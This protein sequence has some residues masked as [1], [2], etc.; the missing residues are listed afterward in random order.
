MPAHRIISN[1]LAL[2]NNHHD[3]LPLSALGSGGKHRLEPLLK[4][5]RRLHS[6]RSTG[7]GR[8]A[9]DRASC[10]L[11]LRQIRSPP[12]LSTTLKAICPVRGSAAADRRW[13]F[14]AFTEIAEMLRSLQAPLLPQR[15]WQRSRTREPKLVRDKRTP[16]RQLRSAPL[17]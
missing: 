14:S 6:P 8:V 3:L 16:S 4:F 1:P 2:K 11:H 13:I 10:R 15:R 9:D 17:P 7:H 5:P 12:L